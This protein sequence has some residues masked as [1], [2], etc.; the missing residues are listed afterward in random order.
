ME[1]I[2]WEFQIAQVGGALSRFQAEVLSDLHRGRM[3][4]RH[5]VRAPRRLTSILAML[6]PVIALYLMR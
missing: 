6:S 2:M 4:A 5:S 1:P 3:R